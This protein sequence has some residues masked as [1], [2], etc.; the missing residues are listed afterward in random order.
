MLYLFVSHGTAKNK[1]EGIIKMI[2][3]LHL[4]FKPTYRGFE[5]LPT[6]GPYVIAPNHVSLIDVLFLHAKLPKDVA[7]V[8]NE[9]IAKRFWWIKKLRTIIEVNPLDPNAIR[10][11]IRKVREGMPIVLFPEGRISTTNGIMKIYEGVGYIAAREKIKIFPVHIHGPERSTFSYLK[12]K[13]KQTLL[14]K[15]YFYFVYHVKF[16]F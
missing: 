4:L 15:V 10:Q 3:K 1:K 9:E 6:S 5:K 11:I 14:P 7:F 8:A 13:I 16:T 2:E 12:G